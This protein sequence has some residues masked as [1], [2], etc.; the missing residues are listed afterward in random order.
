MGNWV[1]AGPH[2]GRALQLK[3]DLAEGHLLAGNILLK[4]RQPENALTEF[5]EYLRLAPKGEFAVETRG[6]A[7]KIKRVL[8][9][10]K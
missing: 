7:E 4:A 8:D 6:L 5:N 2:V 1:K 3:P 10:K 9:A